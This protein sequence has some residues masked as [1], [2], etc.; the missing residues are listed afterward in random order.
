[1][2]DT[3][4]HTGDRNILLDPIICAGFIIYLWRLIQFVLSALFH[5]SGTACVQKQ[6]S[7]HYI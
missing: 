3:F 7:D 5:G 1:M 4:L 6:V 2:L